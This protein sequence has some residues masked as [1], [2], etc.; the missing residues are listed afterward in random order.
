MRNI[1]SFEE[2][3]VYRSMIGALMIAVMKARYSWMH[4]HLK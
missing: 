1:Q 2:Q 4:R 3:E